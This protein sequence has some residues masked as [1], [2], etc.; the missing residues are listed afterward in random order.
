MRLR[1]AGATNHTNRD[2]ITST[3]QTVAI[4]YALERGG[5]EMANQD[6]HLRTYMVLIFA[7]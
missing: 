2:V 6:F 4:R 3:K 7:G 5:S 1:S